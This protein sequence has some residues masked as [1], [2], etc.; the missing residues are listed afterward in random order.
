VILLGYI[1]VAVAFLIATLCAAVA[2]AATGDF[3]D[4]GLL[5]YISETGVR[6]FDV[7]GADWERAGDL[8]HHCLG[9]AKALHPDLFASEGDREP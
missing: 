9:L 4:H 8:W 3:C 2:Y 6:S 5:C 7:K 1:V